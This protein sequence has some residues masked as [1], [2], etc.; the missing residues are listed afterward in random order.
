MLKYL[1]TNLIISWE[2]R[3]CTT[4]TIVEPTINE[5]E[6]TEASAKFGLELCIAT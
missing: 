3:I 2:V 4:E 6:R 1:L 5:I